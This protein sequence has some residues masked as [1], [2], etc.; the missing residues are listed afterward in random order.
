M[1]PFFFFILCSKIL[2]KAKMFHFLP[3][4]VNYVHKSIATC[5]P[6]FSLN[7]SYII[8][9]FLFCHLAPTSLI[10]IRHYPRIITN[11][12]ASFFFLLQI[13]HHFLLLIVFIVAI[14]FFLSFL[15]SPFSS[16]SRFIIQIFF[17]FTF[18][19]SP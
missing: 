19:L 12:T 11:I 17:F 2:R 15:S 7:N 5:L 1:F 9:Y 14:F 10:C 4:I 13:Y 16:S 18:S 3:S 6:L 8:S